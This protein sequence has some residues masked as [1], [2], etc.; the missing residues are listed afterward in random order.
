M[1]K[2]A[3]SHNGHI[4]WKTL[5][6]LM[7]GFACYRLYISSLFCC[8][9][10]NAPALVNGTRSL[11]PLRHIARRASTRERPHQARALFTS[12]TVA[13]FGSACM[14]LGTI[15]YHVETPLT[16]W[17]LPLCR[18]SGSLCSRFGGG[19]SARSETIIT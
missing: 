3:I 16:I 11:R 4:D 7:M 14:M 2:T 19:L 8:Q 12:N 15:L 9:Q 13:V 5:A 10:R 6:A 17:L 18:A 1:A